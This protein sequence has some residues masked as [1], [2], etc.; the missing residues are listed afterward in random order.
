MQAETASLCRKKAGL[1]TSERKRKNEEILHK[2]QFVRIVRRIMVINF[3]D[4]EDENVLRQALLKHLRIGSAT[5]EDVLLFC[6]ENKLQYSG[7]F[8]IGSKHLKHQQEYEIVIHGKTRA[9]TGAKQFFKW[10][11]WKTILKKSPQFWRFLFDKVDW[12]L[13]FYFN[14]DTLSEIEAHMVITTL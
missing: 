12:Q 11:N 9:P 4:F 5:I 6:K 3:M 1:R 7:P 13:S 8:K 14:N 10:S 2:V